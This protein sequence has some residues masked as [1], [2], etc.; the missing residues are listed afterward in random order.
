MIYFNVRLLTM[1][2]SLIKTLNDHFKELYR[3]H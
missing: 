1:E 2:E 3:V